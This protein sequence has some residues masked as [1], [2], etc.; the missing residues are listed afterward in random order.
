MLLFLCLMFHV[1]L[2]LNGKQCQVN[3]S[4]FMFYV[5]YFT[6]IS[7]DNNKK[8]PKLFVRKLTLVRET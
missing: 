6:M 5:M 2:L 7:F 8:Q 1:L 3:G 4:N